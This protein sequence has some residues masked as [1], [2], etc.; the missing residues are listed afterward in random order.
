QPGSYYFPYKSERHAWSNVPD[1]EDGKEGDYLTDALTDRAL[2][3]METN[4]D[5][6]FF[7]NLWYYTVHTPIQARKDKL[8][9]Y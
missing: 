9:K 5:K 1:M 4:R 3:F 7:L 2:V 6:P 8:E